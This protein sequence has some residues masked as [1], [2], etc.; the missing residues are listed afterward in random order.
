[1]PKATSPSPARIE[2]EDLLEN[3]V[4]A[5]RSVDLADAPS[6]AT[7][8]NEVHPLKSKAMK[9]I[10]DLCEVGLQE[11][12]LTPKRAGPDCTFGR[13]VKDMQGYAV[14]CVLMRG[15]ALGHVHPNGEVNIC[16]PWDGEAP[17]FDGHPPGWVVFPPGSHHVPTVTGGQ[18]LFVY[19][20]P[21]GAVTWDPPPA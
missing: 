16:F 18:M 13:L 3:L 10:R 7:T 15:K 19:F 6:A 17:R 1:M 11:G 5:V 9:R 21:G 2:L 8:L 20:L 14:D 4:P 12:W